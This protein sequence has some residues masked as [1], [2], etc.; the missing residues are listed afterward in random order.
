MADKN[1]HMRNECT[2]LFERVNDTCDKINARL[3]DVN[4]DISELKISATRLTMLEANVHE[5]KAEIFGEPGNSDSGVKNELI[6]LRSTLQIA[7]W[8]G[9]LIAAAMI[10]DFMGR[11]LGLLNKN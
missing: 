8:V 4:D 3:D 2:N 1:D 7:T 5:I 10:A 6:K 9:G 11:F